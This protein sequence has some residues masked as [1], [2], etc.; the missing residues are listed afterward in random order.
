MKTDCPDLADLTIWSVQARYPGDIPDI[1]LADAEAAAKQA[2]P[3]YES[4]LS[5]ITFSEP[6]PNDS[7]QE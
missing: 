3:V 4:V 1:V 5:N 7:P 2:R 6:N